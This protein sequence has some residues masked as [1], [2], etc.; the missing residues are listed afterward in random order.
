MHNKHPHGAMRRIKREM[1]DPAEID[2]L[3]RQCR[4]MHL[5]LADG[6]MPFLVPVY[7]GYDG[8]SLY[9][10]S[11]REGSKI[12][13]LQRNNQVCFE[14][15]IEQGVVEAE[16]VCDFEA[17]HKT[18]IGI[19]KA[20]FVEDDAERIT[21]L[22]LIVAQFTTQRFEYPA[23]NLRQTLVIRIDI[24]SMKGKKHGFD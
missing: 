6:G 5:A 3:L 9:F 11:A 8:Q 17:R 12:S 24:D 10:H 7:Y 22:N 16:A 13:L 15:G 19:G 18:V 14:I 4:I 21:A 23:T 1:T 20:H 2:A